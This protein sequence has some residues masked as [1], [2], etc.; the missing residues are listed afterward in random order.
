MRRNWGTL[1]LVIT[2]AIGT[3]ACSKKKND[4]QPAATNNTTSNAQGINGKNLVEGNQQVPQNQ[5]RPTAPGRRQTDNNNIWNTVI[6][7]TF[8]AIAALASRPPKAKTKTQVPQYHTGI[9]TVAPVT[10]GTSANI[11]YKYKRVRKCGYFK[12]RRKNGKFKKKAKYK[13]VWATQRIP[14]SNEDDA[15]KNEHKHDKCKTADCS[16]KVVVAVKKAKEEKKDDDTADGKPAPAPT[17]A[18]EEDSRA[19]EKEESEKGEFE[20]TEEEETE[21]VALI[22]QI[23]DI[24]DGYT[25]TLSGLLENDI[26]KANEEVNTAGKLIAFLI[27]NAEK[28]API[29]DDAE[30]QANLAKALKF[31]EAES[32]ESSIEVCSG[33]E[34][35]NDMIK[36]EGTRQS[37]DLV[38]SFIKSSST[39]SSSDSVTTNPDGST[40][41]THKEETVTN[42]ESLEGNIGILMNK[43]AEMGQKALLVDLTAGAEIFS[44]FP[45]KSQEVVAEG[46]E[47]GNLTIKIDSSST[48]E[49][50]L[51][52]VRE[53][54]ANLSISEDAYELA[55]SEGNKILVETDAEGTEGE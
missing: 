40:T 22:D 21:A 43:L 25:L 48:V 20:E 12:E 37:V 34:C 33:D 41:V 23:N 14:V 4:D 52:E 5:V 17:K 32:L 28:V 31:L 11:T 10:P 27:A 29:Q 38:M 45:F 13:C 26:V 39:S 19:V 3:T 50:I 18:P 54:I 7:G 9:R 1:I 42:S 2:L 46:E 47:R 53:V 51:K 8:D 35:N 55:K 24:A 30:L 16:I 36:G 6:D 49:A 44:Y 15:G